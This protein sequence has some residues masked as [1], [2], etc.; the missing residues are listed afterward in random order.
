MR[1]MALAALRWL[2]GTVGAAQGGAEG[3]SGLA[4]LTDREFDLLK[5][6]VDKFALALVG[7][8]VAFA[9]ALLLERYKRNQAVLAELGK[10]RAEA[11]TAVFSRLLQCE[12]AHH[13]LS[14]SILLDQ[15]EPSAPDPELQLVRVRFAKDRLAQLAGRL[16][17]EINGARLLLGDD[18]HAL[19]LEY[20]SECEASLG[21]V[22]ERDAWGA[23][24]RKLDES[25]KKMWRY[26]PALPTE[27]WLGKL[28]RLLAPDEDGP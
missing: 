28:R 26:L 10:K 21:A 24:A 11:F 19:A 22:G 5:L 7:A 23:H 25:R 15:F 16:R 1:T 6:V 4:G 20:V 18:L 12:S 9:A 27:A 8:L 17:E 2:A 14:S 13:D 3:R